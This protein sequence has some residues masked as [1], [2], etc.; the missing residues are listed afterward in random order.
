MRRRAAEKQPVHGLGLARAAGVVIRR[1][2]RQSPPEPASRTLRGQPGP[3]PGVPAV[4]E[5]SGRH[6]CLPGG[7][8]SLRAGL[9]AEVGDARPR[10]LA[11]PAGVRHADGRRTTAGGLPS[12]RE[13]VPSHAHAA[14]RPYCAVDSTL[15]AAKARCLRQKSPEARQRSIQHRPGPWP[16]RCRCAGRAARAFALL[17]ALQSR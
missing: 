6:W 9:A 17:P 13:Q 4:P 14:W 11:A 15:T 1:C 12:A 3:V 16:G 7:S 5:P 10:S 8:G 2:S